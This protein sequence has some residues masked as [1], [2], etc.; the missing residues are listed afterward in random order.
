M[1][2]NYKIILKSIFDAKFMHG[3]R[4]YLTVYYTGTQS[5]KILT[6]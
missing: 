2:G 5:L 3:G 6:L 4:G 1:K